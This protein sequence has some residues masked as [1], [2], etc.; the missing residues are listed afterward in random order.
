M[1]G[2]GVSAAKGRY[3]YLLKECTARKDLVNG[4]KVHAL[5][6][7]SGLGS[8]NLLANQVIRMYAALGLLSMANQVFAK[9]PEPNEHCWAAIIS[10]HVHPPHA[11]R[12]IDLY[13]QLRRSDM[14]PNEYI[15]AAV[16]K[17]C[18]NTSDV[19]SGKMVHADAITFGHA[20]DIVVGN[21]LIDMY[22][23]NGDVEQAQ[24]IFNALKSP[25]V[26]SWTAMI[27]G[28]VRY[29]LS[30]Q[31]LQLFQRMCD[32]G[33]LPNS[34]TLVTILKACSSFQSLDVGL[35]IHRHVE[36]QGLEEDL[37]LTSSLVSMYSKCGRIEDARRTFDN[38]KQCDSILFNAMIAGYAEHGLG[39]QGLQLFRSMEEQGVVPDSVTFLSVLKACA[40]IGALDEGRNIHRLILDRGYEGNV[41]IGNTLVDMYA[42]CG[43]IEQARRIFDGLKLRCLVS[44]SAL[45]S[46]YA[47]HDLGEQ[48]V[49]LFEKMIQQKFVPNCVTFLAVLK[50][51]GSMRSLSDGK[52]IHKEI[53]NVKLLDHVSIGNA[54]VDMYSKCGSVEEARRTFDRL[55]HRDIVSWSTMISGYANCGLGHQALQVFSQMREE[56][57]V[58]NGIT[59]LSLLKACGS[60]AALDEGREIHRLIVQM[61]LQ[62]H[63]NIGNALVDMYSKCGDVEAAQKTFDDLPRKD[64]F[65]WT[66]MIVGYAHH[67][68]ARKAL[69][70]YEEMQADGVIPNKVTF[71]G[72]ITAC[73]HAG[74]AEEGWNL[75][76]DIP[77]RFGITPD[78][79]H[80]AS[81]VDL[82]GRSGY[83]KEAE[84]FVRNMPIAPD[85]A[86][87]MALLAACQYR[88]NSDIARNAFKS[89]IQLDSKSTAAYVLLSN[90]SAAHG[91]PEEG[92]ETRKMMASEGIMKIPGRTWI[93]VRNCVHTFV[94]GDTDHPERRHIGAML[95][96]LMRALEAASALS[97][98]K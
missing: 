42:K 7:K 52:K 23:K 4:T 82:L 6:V 48:A 90:M 62:E 78:L 10:A 59:F 15:L 47:N 16:L 24:E 87:W 67:G 76:Q 89:L 25:D 57:V 84:E 72:L 60:I 5:I 55:K 44:W 65:S 50:A 32:M 85:A 61:G 95:S 53:V 74:L 14:R 1:D 64:V 91:K 8:D 75:F 38:V 40:S 69:A 21:I 70:L 51:C 56:G 88:A 39:E 71:L 34:V 11:G 35:T 79:Q 33:F 43:D 13:H 68:L 9:L 98:P 77:E 36:G 96:I 93:Q 49:Q 41:S 27:S 2:L 12:A 17:A 19:Q 3:F 81:M 63:E 46:G 86:V 29:G 73:S 92:V 94:V 37:F 83:L 58:P 80:Y 45:I 97:R 20:S 30:E 31:A 18:V 22:M 66:A 26:V 54:L 28:S